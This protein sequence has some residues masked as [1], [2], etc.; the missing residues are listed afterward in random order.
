MTSHDNTS[1]GTS[2][3]SGTYLAII[4]LLTSIDALS[5]DI[6]LPALAVLGGELGVGNINHTTLVVTVFFLGMALGQLVMGPLSDAYG[7]KPI[8]LWGYSLFI[9][10]CVLSFIAESW[11]V[12]IIAR[13]PQGLGAAGPRVI[14]VAIVRDEY[15]GRAMAQRGV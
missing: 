13:W 11:S 15:K 10:G 3:P 9:A 12:K 7:R 14:A 5:T 2:L 8:V 1:N 6:M 4:G